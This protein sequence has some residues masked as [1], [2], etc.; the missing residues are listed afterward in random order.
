MLP[1]KSQFS[2]CINPPD[3]GAFDAETKM[4]APVLR[5]RFIRF[6]RAINESKAPKAHVAFDSAVNADK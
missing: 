5:M 4:H 3:Q 2:R 1:N 6:V